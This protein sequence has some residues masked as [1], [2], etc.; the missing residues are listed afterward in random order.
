DILTE[1]LSPK[2]ITGL[3]KN[4]A[5]TKAE[6][7]LWKTLPVRAKKLEK[8][9]ASVKIKKASQIYEL[10][11]A[12]PGDEILFLLC[13]SQQRLVVDRLK[14]FLQKYLITAQEV[15]EAD[16]VEKGG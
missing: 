6:Q 2:D 12:T 15:T 1:K 11:S 10:L 13:R 14:N 7:N 9:L 5:L 8:A 16:V 3:V 4:T